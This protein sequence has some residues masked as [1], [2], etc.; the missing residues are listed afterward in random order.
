MK[1][2]YMLNKPRGLVS[3]CTDARCPTVL[4][5]FPEEEREGLFH[6]GRLDKDTEGLLL[7]TDDGDLCYRLMK[8]EYKVEKTYY[9]I[10]LGAL[11][12]EQSRQ[13][14]S[15][16][17]IY[18]D[19]DELTR[20][21]RLTVL[22]TG[23]RRDIPHLLSYDELKRND[24][25]ADFPTLTG[26]LTITE[27]KKH[28]VRRMLKAFGCHIVYLKR[29][30]IGQITLDESLGLGEYRP[31]TPRELASVGVDVDEFDK[32]KGGDVD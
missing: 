16:V 1:R 32:N 6:V 15:G 10:A 31:L 14:E 22:A 9:F 25:R 8:P 2:Y 5:C 12:E 7:V 26:M 21:A 4:S 27:G 13:M 23:K 3:A 28:Q 19:K 29:L 17:S 11:T 18:N 20:P 30:S 24:R